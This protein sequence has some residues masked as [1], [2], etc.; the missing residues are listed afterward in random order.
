MRFAIG[1]GSS[2]RYTLSSEQAVLKV[3]SDKPH[4]CTIC[5]KRFALACNL[6]AHLKTHQQNGVPIKSCQPASIPTSFSS[7][8]S[9]SS[10]SLSSSSSPLSSS[11]ASSLSSTGSSAL[12]SSSSTTTTT[13]PSLSSSASS[14]PTTT[15]TATTTTSPLIGCNDNNNDNLNHNNNNLLSGVGL[16]NNITP[17][18]NLTDEKGAFNSEANLQFFLMAASILAIKYRQQQDNQQQQST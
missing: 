5:D 1:S 4:V 15:V 6:R 3:K 17:P 7:S 14:L 10:S 16:L 11:P 8:H 18:I 9:S 12:S 13:S 2:Q